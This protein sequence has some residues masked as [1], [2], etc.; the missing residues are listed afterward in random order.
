M[1]ANN[2]RM[3]IGLE[4]HAQVSSKA[5]LFSG[6]ST[7]FGGLPNHQVSFVDAAFPGMLPVLNEFVLHQAVKT[8]LAING[9]I[10]PASSFD[11]KHYFYPD[12]PQGYQ[13]TQFYSPIIRGGFISVGNGNK[14]IRI[15][16]IHLEQDAGK[17]M[18]DLSEHYT[19]IDLNRSGIALMEIITEPDIASAEEA[20]EFLKEL[21]L[22]LQYIG[23]CDGNMENGSLRCD[24][25]VSVRHID[26]EELGERCE[27]KNLNSFRHIMLA[28]NYE[29]ERQAACIEAGKVVA[30]ETRLFNPD[31]GTTEF[32]RRKEHYYE[33]HYFK[34]PDLPTVFL[35]DSFVENIRHSMPEL[36]TEKI[37]RYVNNFGL[38]HNDARLIVDEQKCADFFEQALAYGNHQMVANWLVVELFGFLNKNSLTIAQSPV[39][40]SEL[41]SL[42]DLIQQ[43]RISGKLAKQVFQTMCQTGKSPLVIIEEQGLV[44]INNTAELDAVID[45]VLQENA[46]SVK[47]F[48]AGKEKLFG[49]FVGCVMQKTAGKANPKVVNELLRKKLA[50]L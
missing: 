31:A 45:G 15:R 12:L 21:R 24:A 50:D 13:I 38:K 10:N 25:N 11:R 48:K 32:M 47:E 34:D 22:L 4:I 33:Y 27:I 30:Q 6:A 16:S 18:H 29:A 44:Q 20:G 36:P 37:A 43:G 5:K 23:V 42:V 40:A 17:S 3:D 8:G 1:L 41:A 28:I 9:S 26:S 49:F 35:D 2:W 19:Y 14:K 39:Q 7:E 46:D